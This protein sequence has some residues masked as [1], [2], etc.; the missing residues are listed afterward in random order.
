[1]WC[2][3]SRLAGPFDD[4][5]LLDSLSLVDGDD[6]VED[7]A[8]LALQRRALLAV[9]LVQRVDV[10]LLPL[11]QLDELLLRAQLLDR[12]RIEAELV[13]ANIAVAEWL[14]LIG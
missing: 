4:L 3:P 12:Q 8:V 14:Q 5:R 2:S 10:L 9:S 1:M 13:Y 6:L 11:R 7:G